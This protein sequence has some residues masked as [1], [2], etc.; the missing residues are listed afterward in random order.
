MSHYVH[1]VPGRMRV[2]IPAI[3]GRSTRAERLQELLVPH[4]GIEQVRTNTLTGSVVVRYDPDLIG[5][6]EILNILR[7]GR[8]VD[9]AR[10]VACDAH[11]VESTRR[12]G[13]A[14]GRAAVNW[15]LG[16]AL[17]ASGLGFLAALI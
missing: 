14:I 13:Q 2:K 3:Q 9:D 7:Y 15:V 10:L 5:D 6:D 1:S 11:R 8:Y 12:A 16:R 4:L 17:E